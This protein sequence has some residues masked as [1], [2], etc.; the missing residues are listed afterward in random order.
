MK[1]LFV[2]D[3]VGSPGREMLNDYLPRLKNKY[4]PD[5]IIANGE[6]AAG[7]RGINQEIA[8]SFFSWGVHVI[9][10]GNHTWDNRDI[11]QF[12]D[13]ES[14]LIRPANYPAGTPGKGYCLFEINKT[15]FAVVNLMGRTFLPPLDDPFRVAKGIVDQLRKTTPFIFVDFHAE[16]TSEKQAMGWFLD[17][18]VSAVVGTHTHVQTADERVL[19]QGTAYITD[20]GMVGP[21]NTVLGMNKEGVLQKFLTQL[22]VRFEVGDGPTQF[23]AVFIELDNK[24]GMARRIQRILIDER[25]LFIES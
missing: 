1:V 21:S 6:N 7:G 8:R 20:V 3:V 24:S 22:P 10:M 17:G 13:E 16:A 5:V 4:Q 12:I 23:N 15:Q 25:H 2:G 19:P 11:F 9:T 18:K 14:R